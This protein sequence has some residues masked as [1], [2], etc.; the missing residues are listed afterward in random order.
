MSDAVRVQGEGANGAREVEARTP[1]GSVGARLDVTNPMPTE[2]DHCM[3][4]TK[5]GTPCKSPNLKGEPFCLG[6]SRAA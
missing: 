1:Q 6:H 3:M 5:A 4:L 2:Y